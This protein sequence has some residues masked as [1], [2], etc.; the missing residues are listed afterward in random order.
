MSQVFSGAE[1]IYE[2]NRY[3]TNVKREDAVW[4]TLEIKSDIFIANY[5]NSIGYESP[6]CSS[7]FKYEYS[8]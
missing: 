3:Q 8:N 5:W 2:W 4:D 7:I 6:E 1:R